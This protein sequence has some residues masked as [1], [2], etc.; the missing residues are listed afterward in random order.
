MSDFTAGFASRLDDAAR[1]LALSYAD[2]AEGF[3]PR[4]LKA[5]AGGKP[6]PAEPAAS[7]PV[8]FSPQPIGARFAP[9]PGDMAGD[10]SDTAG[11]VAD[12][13]DLIATARAAGYTE[14]FRDGHEQGELE[15]ERDQALLRDLGAALKSSERVDRDLIAA[16]L[17]QTVLFLVSKIVGDIGVAPEL[18][19]RRIEA[20]TDLIAEGAETAILRVNPEDLPLLGD[21]LPATL[22]PI[23]DPN[24]E[25]G[26]FVLESPATIVEEGPDLWLEQL[27]QA[28]D[29]VG[30]P[31]L[32]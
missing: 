28:I 15:R 12:A 30:V 24:V 26:S 32:C 4:D 31:P 1:A 13:G 10:G 21:L 2:A 3:A 22:H 29:R 19:A 9:P 27:A 11:T 5:R 20:A 6:Q 16:R 8:S 17:R 14:G 7:G 25:R 18:L 23:G